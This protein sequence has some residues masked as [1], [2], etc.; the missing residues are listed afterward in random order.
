[1]RVEVFN[2]LDVN[3]PTPF[4]SPQPVTGFHAG[5]LGL[6]HIGIA[7]RDIDVTERFYSEVLGFGISDYQIREGSDGVTMKM[8]FMHINPREH[9]I[10]IANTPN[11]RRLGH[12]MTQL[13]TLDDVGL[14]YDRVMEKGIEVVT[15][16]GRHYN[17][18]MVSFYMKSPSGFQVEYGWGGREID[19][20]KWSVQLRSP[21]SVW[22]HSGR[23]QQDR[24]NRIAGIFP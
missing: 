3:T 9:S 18:Q 19:V 12:W 5:D 13:E 24:D 14:G 20:D 22:G 4:H 6:G 7:V 17:D 23:A 8:T 21:G 11:P 16:L 1:M 15:Q 2:A 10:V